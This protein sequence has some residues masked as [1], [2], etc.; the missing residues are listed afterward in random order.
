MKAFLKVLYTYIF[1]FSKV[2]R[3]KKFGKGS[4]IGKQL[5]TYGSCKNIEIGNNVRIGRYSRLSA[6]R[7][8]TGES[9]GKIIIKD[10][11]Y[12]GDH[13]RILTAS[14]VELEENVLIASCVVIMG[15]N[16]SM[17][18]ENPIP[19][20]HQ[21]LAPAPVTIKEGAWIGENVSILPGVTVGKRSIIGTGAVV[22]KDVPDYS[23]AVGNPARIIKKYNFDTHAWE[24]V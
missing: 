4:F 7:A 9:E 17:D 10:G 23:I 14:K 21:P 22:T 24:K 8:K 18:P 15:E 16:H 13:F 6:Y 11:C 20:K 3:F 2:I 5:I 12:I 1:N 19:Y